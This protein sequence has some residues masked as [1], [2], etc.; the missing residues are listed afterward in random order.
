MYHIFETSFNG[1]GRRWIDEYPTET[2]ARDVA[3]QLRT[4]NERNGYTEQVAW[5]E[6]EGKVIAEFPVRPINERG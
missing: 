3:R 4:A 5:V 1:K 6:L 2:L